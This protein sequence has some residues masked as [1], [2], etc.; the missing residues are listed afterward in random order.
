MYEVDQS[1]SPHPDP[2]DDLPATQPYGMDSSPSA[3]HTEPLSHP[4]H[5]ETGITICSVLYHNHYIQNFYSRLYS[6]TIVMWF[7][8]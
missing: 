1:P 2:S 8:V 5:S 3:P 7:T 6:Y 4:Q